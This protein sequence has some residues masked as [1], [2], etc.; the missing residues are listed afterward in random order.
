[1]S[2][3]I[4]LALENGGTIKSLLIN[5]QDI[6]GP[7]L[8]LNPNFARS[9]KLDLRITFTRSSSTTYAGGG[10]DSYINVKLWEWYPTTFFCV[11]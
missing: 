2:N 1:V 4:K 11:L 3:F 6:S 10:K 8:S 7:C 5:S 9:Q